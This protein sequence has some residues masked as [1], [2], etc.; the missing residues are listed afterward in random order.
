M[1]LPSLSRSNKFRIFPRSERTPRPS[2]TR[3]RRPQSNVDGDSHY[4]RVQLLTNAGALDHDKQIA[5]C[6]N[7]NR[8]VNAQRI[9][10]SGGLAL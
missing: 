8:W 7:P 1:P 9:E 5:L 10:V 6:R 4:V 2:F 3:C